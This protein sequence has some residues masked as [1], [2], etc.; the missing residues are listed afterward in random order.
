[1]TASEDI[2][3]A[4]LAGV[5][6][7]TAEVEKIYSKKLT[8]VTPPQSTANWDSGPKNTK[9]IDLLI[10]EIRFTVTGFIN[11]GDQSTLEDA[12]EAGGVMDFVWDGNTYSVNIEKISIKKKAKNEN[13]EKEIM[14]TALTGVNI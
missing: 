1:M 8:S 5:T 3:N 9:I 6:I 10:I 2:P 14:F 4:T 13:S 7:Y 11:D 12:V